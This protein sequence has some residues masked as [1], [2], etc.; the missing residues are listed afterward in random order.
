[1][2][3]VLTQDEIDELLTAINAGDTNREYIDPATSRKIRT[4]DFKRPD[5]FLKNQCKAFSMTHG[6]FSRL[7]A[8]SLSTWLRSTVHVNVASVDPLT[9]EEFVRSIPSPTVLAVVGMEPYNG[10]A[11][12][13]IDPAISF[14]IIDRMFGGIG[15]GTKYQH[16]LTDIE[17]SVMEEI[18]VHL[19]GNMR[20]AWPKA[21]G[22]QPKLVRIDTDPQLVK[23]AHHTD[24]VLLVT[25]EAKVGDVEGMINLCVPHATL[26]P[27][28]GKLTN[29][30][31]QYLAEHLKS[32]ETYL[33]TVTHDGWALE[34]VP[35]NLKTTEVCLAAVRSDSFG[36][37][38]KHV[39]EALRTEELCLIAVRSRGSNLEYVPTHIKT[40]AFYLEMVKS[41]TWMFRHVPENF[42]TADFCLEAVKHTKGLALEHMPKQLITA[43]LCLEA[44]KH[45]GRILRYVPGSI[46]TEEMCLA[47]KEI[48]AKTP[49]TTSDMGIISGAISVSVGNAEL[50]KLEV[51]SEEQ[52]TPEI[53]LEAVKRNG[54]LLEYVPEE[55]RTAEICLEAVKSNRWALEYVPEELITEKLCLAA[56]QSDGWALKHMPEKLRTAKICL[57]AVKS[58]GALLEYVPEEIRMEEMRIEAAKTSPYKPAY[59]L[60]K[61]ETDFSF[62][63]A[64]KNSRIYRELLETLFG[65][66]NADAALSRLVS[67]FQEQPFDFIRR[68]NPNYLLECIYPEHPQVIAFVLTRLDP[69]KAAHVL[70]GLFPAMRSDVVRRVAT[71]DSANAEALRV[72]EQALKKNLSNIPSDTQAA[73]SNM[74]TADIL[75]HIDGISEKEIIKALEE[76]N[77]ELARE[78]RKRIFLFEDIVEL[79]GISVQKYMREV[80]SQVLC[81]ALKGVGIKVKD[82]I[83]GN[84][85]KQA[86]TMLKEDMEYM[87]LIRLKEVEEARQKNVSVIRHL[88]STDQIVIPRLRNLSPIDSVSLEVLGKIE[89]VL[90]KKLSIFFNKFHSVNGGVGIAVEILSCL[91]DRTIEKDIIEALEDEDP[92]LAEYIKSRMFMFEDIPLL[93][94]RSIQKFLREIDALD[95]SKALKGAD[96]NVREAIFR[97]ISSRAVTMIKEDMEYLGTISYKDIEDAQKK[98]VSVIRHLENTDQIVIPRSD[99]ELIA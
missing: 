29:E 17:R 16:E 76:E 77:D 96:N 93:D 78:I 64:I 95:L 56:V 58:S 60:D 6:I 7:S 35:E 63:A 15:E 1:M 3:E 11:V 2:T 57:E 86:A 30:V 4:Y 85:S 48:N 42:R 50:P 97:N 39:P 20:V 53:C 38:L 8:A 10:N 61:F 89:R 84:M 62:E 94:N 55:L 69:R 99:E 79:D 73:D 34:Y 66:H 71:I 88:E 91:V 19:L 18:A 74:R 90:E 36:D 14:S 54:A 75:S 26:K 52:K 47:A 22:L 46:K 12:I 27:I 72:V 23:I 80:D 51:T 70:Q 83:F 45:D 87:G 40:M 65:S 13:E 33:E 44:V 21:I 49:E 37:T 31:F 43:E 25:L 82:K 92:E 32:P 81:K 5:K 98:I 9:Y 24:M 67:R 41:R 59:P 68:A 28:I